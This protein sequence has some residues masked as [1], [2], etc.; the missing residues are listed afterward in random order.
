MLEAERINQQKLNPQQELELVSYIEDFTK[1]ELSSTKEMIQNFAS[2]IATEPVSD[3][4][5]TC[6]LH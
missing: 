6:F 3:A 1:R 5:V 4:W 2:I